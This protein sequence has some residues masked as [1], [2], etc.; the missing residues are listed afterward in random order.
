MLCTST[1]SKAFGKL[2]F[3]MHLIQIF[4]TSLCWVQ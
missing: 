2:Y 4:E 1:N 3:S